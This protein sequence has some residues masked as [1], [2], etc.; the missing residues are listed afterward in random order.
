MSM[1]TNRFRITFAV[2]CDCSPDGIFGI[3]R[4][5][6]R[7]FLEMKM[8]KIVLCFSFALLVLSMSVFTTNRT[9]ERAF[10]NT[11]YWGTCN[12][13][14]GS[15]CPLCVVPNCGTMGPGGE[16]VP[17]GGS[18][19]CTN[20]PGIPRGTSCPGWIGTCLWQPGFCGIVK[21][22]ECVYDDETDTWL[23]E[24]VVQT[25]YCPGCQ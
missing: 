4:L 3:F 17:T 6:S 15:V 8:K 24:C 9:S 1:Q 22:S 2:R 14:A 23:P 21:T 19:G 5:K 25:I 11:R 18:D 13:P 12:I 20:N 10:A 16:P 7:I